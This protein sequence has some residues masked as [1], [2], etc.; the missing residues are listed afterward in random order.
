MRK[1]I[2]SVVL[3]LIALSGCAMQTRSNYKPQNLDAES[4]AIL[5]DDL[6]S[7]IA[8]N[9][10]AKSTTFEVESDSLSSALGEALKKNGYALVVVSS[11]HSDQTTAKKLNYTVDWLSNDSL[12]A[13]VT[14][15][16]ERYTRAYTM[17]NGKLIPKGGPIVGVMSHE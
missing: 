8:A 5:V 4:T 10:A 7:T 9:T 13:T 15:G 14:V 16:E 17:V 11:Q 1:N 6:A 12:Y 3:L 2:L